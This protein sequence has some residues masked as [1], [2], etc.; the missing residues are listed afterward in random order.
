MLSVGT[1]VNVNGSHK[2][3]ITGYGIEDRTVL[4]LIEMDSGFYSQDKRLYVSTIVAHSDNVT[5]E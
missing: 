4:Y 3:T 2:G 5:E 1:R